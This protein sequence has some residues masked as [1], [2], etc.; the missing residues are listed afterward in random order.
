MSHFHQTSKLP[1]IDESDI[2]ST[3]TM[4]D[5]RFARVRSLGEQSLQVCP[6]LRVCDFGS[7]RFTCRETD[8]FLSGSTVG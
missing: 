4:N 8:S 1:R 2:P 7:H 3:M 5:D 6:G